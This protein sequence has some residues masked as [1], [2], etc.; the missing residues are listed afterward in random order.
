MKDLDWD[1]EPDATHYA[2]G[3]DVF[4]EVFIKDITS[5]SY[6]FRV[7]GREYAAGDWEYA[8]AIGE[9]E[10]DGLIERA[11]QLTEQDDQLVYTV[12]MF[13][14][15]IDPVEGMRCEIKNQYQS[16]YSEFTILAITK[17]HVIVTELCSDLEIHFHRRDITIKHIEG[18]S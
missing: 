2:P 10:L 5:Y 17:D 12:T 15:G 18:G 13:I 1:K 4:S 6:H 8:D 16:Q 7:K 3:D 11:A 14:N 9:N